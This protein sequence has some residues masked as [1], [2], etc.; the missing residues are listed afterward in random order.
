MEGFHGGW[1]GSGIKMAKSAI[2]GQNR[3]LISVPNRGGTSTTYAEPKWYRYQDKVVP[4]PL[5]RTV[6]V[7]VPIQVVLV[8]LLPTTLFFGILTLLSSILNTKGIGTQ[9]ND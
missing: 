6:L 2:S 5:T 7:P 4:V 8:P 9:L 1:N 3:I